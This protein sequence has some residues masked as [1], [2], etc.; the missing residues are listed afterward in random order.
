[1]TS[2]K[3]RDYRW[4]LW[5]K[6]VRVSIWEW[7]GERSLTEPIMEWCLEYIKL[8]EASCLQY[9]EDEDDVSMEITFMHLLTAQIHN[10]YMHNLGMIGCVE[11]AIR[12]G[13]IQHSRDVV[14]YMIVGWKYRCYKRN[15]LPCIPG[16]CMVHDQDV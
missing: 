1:M 14:K 2:E 10:L 5:D 3:I 9:E 11:N 7:F 12:N 6:T 4:S 13:L 8:A 15:I 16:T